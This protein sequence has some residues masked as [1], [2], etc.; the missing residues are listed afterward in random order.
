[1][2]KGATVGGYRPLTTTTSTT[3]TTS[4][5]T[6]TPTTTATTSWIEMMDAT[7]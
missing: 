2:R 1:M 6:M 4:R 3:T 5:T 7:N